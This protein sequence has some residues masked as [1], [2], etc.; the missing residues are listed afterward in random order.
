MRRQYLGYVLAC[1]AWILCLAALAGCN[2]SFRVGRQS[3][4]ATPLPTTAIPSPTGALIGR[5]ESPTLTDSPT[6]ASSPT[7][8]PSSTPSPSATNT[9]SPTPVSPTPT[10]TPPGTATPQMRTY[11]VQPGDTLTD[12]AIRHGAS[13]QALIEA[14]HIANP[15]VI[16]AGATLIIPEA[17]DDIVGLA[18][19][20]IVVATARPSPAATT[21]A[22]VI[23]AQPVAT[24]LATTPPTRAPGETMPLPPAVYL[25]PMTHEYQRLNNCA[26]V[27]IAMVL[28]YY[29]ITT[30][31]YDLAPIL[32]GSNQDRNVRADEIADYLQSIGFGAQVRVNGD[33]ELV[34]RLV[35]NG[36]P[37]IVEQWLERPDDELTGHFRLVRGYDD[38]AGTMIANDSYLGPNLRL[39]YADF[40][41][42]WRAFNRTYIPIYRPEQEPLVR[43][44][45]G[46]DWDDNAMYRKSLD[47]AR[48]ETQEQNDLYAWFNQGDSYLGL[49][50]TAEA[51]AAYER[52]LSFPLPPRFL[53][54][55]YGP[56]EA[57]NRAGEYQK[58]IDLATR[59]LAA[60]PNLE[61]AHYYQGGAYEGLNRIAEA[62]QAYQK[63][64][65]ANPR[66]Q[67]AQQ[68][69]RRLQ[70]G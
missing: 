45:I 46:Q 18:T 30:T 69:L 61:E 37:V 13:V 12:I 36:I 14:N 63:A 22:P 55:R 10:L 11:V 27:T 67:P 29:G 44:I 68:A 2:L 60:V 35:A 70:A 23:I 41:R 5:V 3:K 65:Q 48:R 32:K 20:L 52:A 57:Y 49:G 25:N 21:M 4:V 62:M 38:G 1:F 58:A 43:A 42:M 17:R 34:R 24:P 39:R 33:M 6:P 15:D 50:Q 40:D 31:Q 47:T 66:Y 56:L 26:P 51:I 19:P 64:A 16:W 59:V 53:W 28:S 8:T 7:P 9:P 54:Y